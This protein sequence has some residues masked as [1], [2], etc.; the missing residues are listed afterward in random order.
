[1]S[2]FNTPKK[3]RRSLDSYDGNPRTP[4]KMRAS[5]TSS[6]LTKLG[7][8]ETQMVAVMPRTYV[9]GVTSVNDLLYPQYA[10]YQALKE[11]D[12]EGSTAKALGSSWLR[13]TDGLWG[14]LSLR[15]NLGGVNYSHGSATAFHRYTEEGLN[16]VSVPKLK[17]Q[18]TE[19]F[20]KNV[21][22]KCVVKYLTPHITNPLQSAPNV[23]ATAYLP[24][25]KFRFMVVRLKR[26]KLGPAMMKYQKADGDSLEGFA[27]LPNPLSK[28][29]FLDPVG[30]PFGIDDESLIVD[31]P[32]V[33]DKKRQTPK[34]HFDAP[35]QKKFF[36]VMCSQDFM[37]SPNFNDPYF[38]A[39][40]IPTDNFHTGMS[41]PDT[42]EISVT[43]PVNELVEFVKDGPQP[44]TAIGT[45]MMRPKDL[46]LYD[47][48]IVIYAYPPGD[49]MDT[50]KNRLEAFDT[51][52]PASE[53]PV[54][55]THWATC[56]H[57]IFNH[58]GILE[59]VDSPAI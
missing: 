14:L 55:G 24:P 31:G 19:A 10:D 13:H 51:G 3:I 53:P 59:T 45:D 34:M 23:T 38:E 42:K 17:L 29:L 47:T 22:L 44:P 20:V 48:K 43:I 33:W 41:Y 32:Y 49:T 4:K 40:P 11:G 50:W 39:T 8:A 12:A 9:Q 36:D 2:A 21:H 37:L 7:L 28:E 18:G 6:R 15:Y 57:V 56:P 5:K 26:H 30:K 27:G 1:M 52:P 46:N 25:M 16:L 35:V 54:A 58:Y